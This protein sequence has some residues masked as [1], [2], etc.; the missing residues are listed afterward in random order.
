M[1]FCEKCGKEIMDEA[2]ICPGCGCAVKT[3]VKQAEVPYDDC[4]K[5]AATTNIVSAIL[6]VVGVFCALFVNV[7]VGAAL[8]LITEL[9]ALA[10]N[11]KLQKALKNNNKAVDKK[12][13]KNIA[14]EHT[15]DMKSKYSGFKISFA[16]AYIALACLIVFALLGNAMGL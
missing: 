8:C 7:W 4:V 2:V 9:V 11:T 6:L 16:L 14:K 15:K 3:E 10:P 1:R 12:A 5:G 13:L